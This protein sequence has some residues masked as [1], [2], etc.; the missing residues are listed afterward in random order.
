MRTFI[1]VP[2]APPPALK[3][4]LSQLAGH[5]SRSRPIPAS[6]L[7]LTLKFLGETAQPQLPDIQRAIEAAIVGEFSTPAQLVGLGAFPTAAR[8]S[9]LWVGVQQAD[10]L[11]RIANR[12]ETTCP[13][14]GFAKESR[15]F[16][17]HLTLMR[18]KA[19]PAD[20]V[21]E[22][23]QT[24]QQTDFGQI[25]VEQVI[26]YESDFPSAGPEGPTYTPLSTHQ[27]PSAT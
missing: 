9:V 14:F 20:A 23:L 26:H 3:R 18:F 6:N 13:E 11:I 22:L 12:L 5:G 2:V 25:P 16:V 4:V 15:E 19:R 27:L 8:P 21:F 7:H 10:L 1:A 24:E 17:P